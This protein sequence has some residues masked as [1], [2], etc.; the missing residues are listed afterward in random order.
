MPRIPELSLCLSKKTPRSFL[1]TNLSRLP[2][3]GHNKAG[4]SDFQNQRFETR[5]EENAEN[6]EGPSH[7][8]NTRV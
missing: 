4:Q 1:D 3:A 7:P 8:R 2:K 5:Y 6:A